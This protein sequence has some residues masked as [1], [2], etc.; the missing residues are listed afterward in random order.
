MDFDQIAREIRAYLVLQGFAEPAVRVERDDD[1]YPAMTITLMGVSP[2][3]HTWRRTWSLFLSHRW[4]APQ[5]A[6]YDGQVFSPRAMFE[7]DLT[8]AALGVIDLVRHHFPDDRQ[9]ERIPPIIRRRG[10]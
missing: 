10:V 2:S 1:N 7:G 6:P 4:E 9:S 8:P 5:A 3:G